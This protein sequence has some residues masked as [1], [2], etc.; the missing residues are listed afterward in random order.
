MSDEKQRW[1]LA[2]DGSC[3]T[4]QEISDAIAQAC[5]GKLEVLPLDNPQVRYWRAA[6]FGEDPPNAPTLLRIEGAEARAWTGPTMTPPLLRRLGARSTLRVLRSLGALRRQANGHPLEST[7]SNTLGRAGFLRLGGGAALATGIV[8]FGKTPALAEQRCA[9]ARRWVEANANNLPTTYDEIIAYPM[10]Y[11]RAIYAK[12]SPER[13][14]EFWSRH[15]R[16]YRTENPEVTTEQKQVLDEA[17]AVAANPRNFESRDEPTRAVRN[18]EENA[19]AAFGKDESGRV[20]ATLGPAERRPRE[21][22]Q[23]ACECSNE[24]EYCPDRNY[25]Q[26]KSSNCV[27]QDKGCGTFGLYVCNGLCEYGG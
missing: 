19:K 4:C 16:R 9:A 25:C 24:S 18:L 17:A 14:S 5:D 2:F 12:L 15:L 27:F 26:Y 10:A 3:A 1:I 11:R 20:I 22:A 13:R 21:A 23:P 8:L 6:K 7:E